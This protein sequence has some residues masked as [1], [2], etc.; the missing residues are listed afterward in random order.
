LF[1]FA[2]GNTT[3]RD[4]GPV[5]RPYLTIGHGL[6]YACIFN[7]V[8]SASLVAGSDEQIK[9]SICEGLNTIRL[10]HQTV[11]ARKVK[12]LQLEEAGKEDEA[13]ESDSS[14][15]QYFIYQTE[16]EDLDADD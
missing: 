6:L 5:G 9:K 8:K 15:P 14:L 11:Q 1:C 2:A 7:V 4:Y 16:E 3:R 13:A 12:K 10:H